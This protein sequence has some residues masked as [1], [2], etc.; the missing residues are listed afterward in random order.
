MEQP[1]TGLYVWPRFFTLNSKTIQALSLSQ[2]N[3]ILCLPYLFHRYCLFIQLSQPRH[4]LITIT[5]TF[6]PVASSTFSTCSQYSAHLITIPQHLTIRIV[7]HFVPCLLFLFN[8]LHLFSRQ[9]FTSSEIILQPLSPSSVRHSFR[10]RN[11]QFNHDSLCPVPVIWIPLLCSRSGKALLF[12]AT[13]T[14]TSSLHP[15]VPLHIHHWY[16]PSLCYSTF[17]TPFPHSQQNRSR[18]GK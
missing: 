11:F 10:N 12:S 3:V 15:R 9:L 4:H 7:N 17:P 18:E 5:F 16:T 13:A 8:S 1:I 14:P 6:V 2:F